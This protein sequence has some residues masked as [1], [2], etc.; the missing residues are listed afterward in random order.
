M[1]ILVIQTIAYQITP[2]A[3]IGQTVDVDVVLEIILGFGYYFY[4]PLVEAVTV[5]VLEI[6]DH[7]V[8]DFGK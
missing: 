2:A 3:I 1:V 4:Y 7:G 5:D 6:V 8:E